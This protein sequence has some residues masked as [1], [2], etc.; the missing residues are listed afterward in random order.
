MDG[1]RV[2]GPGQ[3]LNIGLGT[4][5]AQGVPIL[6][7]RDGA[8]ERDGLNGRDRDGQGQGRDGFGRDA[9]TERREGAYYGSRGGPQN[10]P[11]AS[12]AA[13]RNNS[14]MGRR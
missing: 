9:P 7:G 5:P 2:L 4:S 3:G 14:R 1:N 8:G 6:V 11:H 12:P 13:K 10:V